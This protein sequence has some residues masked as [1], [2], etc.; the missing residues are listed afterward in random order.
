MSQQKANKDIQPNFV[1]DMTRESN[2]V[3]SNYVSVTTTG[4]DFTLNFL[5]VLPPTKEQVAMAE[6]G[7]DIPSPLQCSV[8]VPNELIPS[9]IEALKTQNEKFQNEISKRESR[10]T[11]ETSKS[12]K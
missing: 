4:L 3:Y 9:L 11:V 5:D 12:K 7:Q 6:K 10:K 2:R 1:P 8:V